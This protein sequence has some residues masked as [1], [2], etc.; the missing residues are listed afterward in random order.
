MIEEYFYCSTGEVDP[1]WH[2]HSAEC[3]HVGLRAI[4]SVHACVCVWVFV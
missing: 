1:R 2:A 3:K 4:M